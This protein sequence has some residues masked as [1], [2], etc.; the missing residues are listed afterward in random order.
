MQ[1]IVPEE[2]SVNDNFPSDAILIE[3]CASL[4][5]L[6]VIGMGLRITTSEGS[7][8]AFLCAS[9]ALDLAAILT[10]G[11]PNAFT[12]FDPNY[13]SVLVEGSNDEG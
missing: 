2:E 4:N 11:V 10:T 12:T 13:E 1:S 6:G 9:Q 3:T 5:A 8:A 7:H